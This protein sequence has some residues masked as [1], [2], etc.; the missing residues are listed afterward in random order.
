[1]GSPTNGMASPVPVDDDEE[2]DWMHSSLRSIERVREC[3]I[4]SESM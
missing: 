2:D 1:M 4:R 3:G